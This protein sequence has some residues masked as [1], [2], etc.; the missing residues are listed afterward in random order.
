[1]SYSFERVLRVSIF[2]IPF[3][4]YLLTLC[5]A[6]GPGDAAEFATSGALLGIPHPPGYPLYTLL[7][8]LCVVLIPFGSA[9]ARVNLL[10][11][12]FGALALGFLYESLR[13]VLRTT[14]AP[15]FACLILAF[16][17]AWWLASVTAEVY[18]MN[19]FYVAAVLWLALRAGNKASPRSLVILAYVFGLALTHHFTI[20]L[21]VPALV[22]ILVGVRYEW[23]QIV[24]WMFLAVVV[25]LSLYI[26]IPVRA[27]MDPPYVFGSP[28]G[29]EGVWH[30]LTAAGYRS[31][32]MPAGFES[33][34]S[35]LVRFP[36]HVAE[37]IP[38]FL[39]WAPVVG[40]VSG[41]TWRRRFLSTV[42]V[43]A[44]PCVA[45][46]L[47][48]SIP[49][50]GSFYLPIHIVMAFLTALGFE[51][52]AGEIRRWAGRAGTVPGRIAS[53]AVAVTASG[54]VIAV[55]LVNLPWCDRSN[56][57]LAE[58]YG[59]GLL[60]TV[61]VVSDNEGILLALGDHA[62]FPCAY[63]KL[64]EGATPGVAVF[65]Q[66]GSI[67]EDLYT[68]PATGIQALERSQRAAVEADLI[69]RNPGSVFYSQRERVADVA[70]MPYHAVGLLFQPRPEPLEDEA[71]DR[72]W[73]SYGFPNMENRYLY[74]DISSRAIG[75]IYFQRRALWDLTH[76]DKMRALES[77]QHAG[78]IAHDVAPV[79]AR[80]VPLYLQL[81]DL[82]GAIRSAEAA[83][84]LSPGSPAALNAVGN[85]YCMAQRWE[86][87]EAAFQKAI[88]RNP[89]LAVL[90]ANLASAH[91]GAGRL[92]T[93]VALLRKALDID[94]SLVNARYNLALA[95]LQSGDQD[96]A[97]VLL[98]QILDERPTH[99][100]A[101]RLMGALEAGSPDF[102]P[103]ATMMLTFFY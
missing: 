52:A 2:G 23:K 4:V 11:A 51:A 5:P 56:H 61:E 85:V 102:P 86:D 8:R 55:F 74:A 53:L 101:G 31:N 45:F 70:G 83:L 84:R 40:I 15:W 30:H 69:R 100:Q 57:R 72:L 90:Y 32:L 49:D 21:V 14:W 10:S 95:R 35:G 67:L 6:A 3:L 98:R 97:S 48:Y 99:P 20:V 12:V 33:V 87:A 39:L 34:K 41:L 92:E 76:K 75:G 88:D 44:V 19:A 62:V 42:A 65:D 63:M 60:G 50:I 7:S 71:L 18:A 94:P 22:L 36:R 38:L 13:I 66:S 16:S 29:A 82:E 77:L 27:S 9:A 26:Y 68:D 25:P 103:G 80:Q 37:G 96:G 91:F 89:D 64:I 24:V 78:T 43:L 93:S 28:Q 46:V 59:R 1:V 58:A 81:R 79:Q 17:K 47:S 73:A 54:F